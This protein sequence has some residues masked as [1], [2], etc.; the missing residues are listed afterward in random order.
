MARWAHNC[1]HYVSERRREPG[2]VD[3]PYGP[4]RNPRLESGQAKEAGDF[5]L[6]RPPTLIPPAL[7]VTGSTPSRATSQQGLAKLCMLETAVGNRRTQGVRCHLP[8]T[9]LGLGQLMGASSSHSSRD[10][11]TCQDWPSRGHRL[12]CIIGKMDS[13]CFSCF[14]KEELQPLQLNR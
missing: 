6:L 10:A 4:P 13:F 2:Q 14:Q 11:S 9:G 8:A 7:E 3:V 5:S 12:P 1:E